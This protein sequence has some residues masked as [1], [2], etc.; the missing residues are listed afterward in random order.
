[1]KIQIIFI[2]FVLIALASTAQEQG[3]I[4]NSK[5]PYVKLKSINIGDCRWTD[6]FC[7]ITSYSIHY[8]KLYE[9]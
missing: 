5:S 8:T 1:M 7:V 6:G 4:N 2:C 9:V 3:I